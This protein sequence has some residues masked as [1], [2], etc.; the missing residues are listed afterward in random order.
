M[1]EEPATIPLLYNIIDYFAPRTKHNSVVLI[2]KDESVI[3]LPYSKNVNFE[4]Y[5]NLPVIATG[6][7]DACSQKLTIKEPSEIEIYTN[8][9]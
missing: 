9:R 8:N 7:Y 3:S 2:R 1:E 4:Q 6:N 5:N